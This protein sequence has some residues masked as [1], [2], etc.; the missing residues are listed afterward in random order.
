[1]TIQI[2]LLW[3]AALLLF[4]PPLTYV[5]GKLVACAAAV[6]PPMLLWMCCAAACLMSTAVFVF[7]L[8]RMGTRLRAWLPTPVQLGIIVLFALCVAVP[9][10]ITLD[11][12]LPLAVYDDNWHCQKMVSVFGSFPD[13]S[14]YLFPELKLSYYFYAYVPPAAVYSLITGLGLKS[15]WAGYVFVLVLSLYALIMTCCNRLLPEFKG[16][17]TMFALMITFLGGLHEW[18]CIIAAWTRGL[19]DWHTEWWAKAVGLDLQVSSLYTACFWAP[20]HICGLALFALC[21]ALLKDR[22]RRGAVC[23]CGLIAG[24]QAGFSA[25]VALAT[26]LYVCVRLI[27]PGCGGLRDRLLHAL[28]FAAG[29]VPV[30]LLVADCFAGRQGSIAFVSRLDRLPEFLFFL[31]IEFGV[32]LA[33]PLMYGFTKRARDETHM[34]CAA[35]LAWIAVLLALVFCVRSSG[36]N[37]ISYRMLLPAQ[38]LLVLYAAAQLERINKGSRALKFAV[39]ALLAV[40]LGGF[41][42]EMLAMSKKQFDMRS[43]GPR[44]PETV[45]AVNSSSG[46]SDVVALPFVPGLNSVRTLNTLVNN[47]FRLK[48]LDAR[49]FCSGVLDRNNCVYLNSADMAALQKECGRN[50]DRFS[51]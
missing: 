49:Y 8:Q 13:F 12:G 10:L 22:L 45:I 21:A 24:V 11:P 27:G 43:G 42:P 26:V 29:S 41:A 15:V 37:V 9:R 36:F 1:M 5:L 51:P 39:Y 50:D 2:M 46:L 28:C 18:P 14:H 23:L 48:K 3:A 16:C 31:A 32:L 20:Q 6:P 38:V 25:Y 34:G 17:R 40:Q 47:I 19:P 4:A 44:L 33:L 7:T 35:D 30:F